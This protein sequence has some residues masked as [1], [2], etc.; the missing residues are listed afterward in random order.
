MTSAARQTRL[1]L[2][3]QLVDDRIRALAAGP[4]PGLQSCA[5]SWEETGPGIITLVMYRG[6]H[7][8]PLSFTEAELL[9]GA[10][11]EG[12][13]RLVG[14]LEAFFRQVYGAQP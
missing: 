2:A 14:K 7:L 13:R 1:L 3:Q 5:Y 6:T 12:G 4:L 9:E 11:G 8:H 10:G